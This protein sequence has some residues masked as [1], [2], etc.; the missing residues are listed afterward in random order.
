[1]QNMQLFQKKREQGATVVEFALVVV[2][3]L[4]IVFGIVEFGIIFMQIHLVENA[5]RE[6]V[7]RG[8]V[9]DTYTCFSETPTGDCPDNVN[10]NRY[11]A[12]KKTIVDYLAAL[13]NQNDLTVQIDRDPDTPN[14]QS[15]QL[16]VHIRAPNFMPKILSALIPLD[17]LKLDKIEYTAT[18]EY[19]N[20]EEP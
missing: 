15:A 9:A 19:E 3:L 2:P 1:M 12:V 13:Y 17:S 4:I 10:V 14:S 8:V 5:A 18:G 20:P 7:R 11:A 16:T 6:G